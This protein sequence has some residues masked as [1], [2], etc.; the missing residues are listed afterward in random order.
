MTVMNIVRPA[1]PVIIT[2]LLLATP[3]LAQSGRTGSGQSQA[4]AV[5]AADIQRLQDQVYDARNWK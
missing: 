3:A 4:G 2:A 5:T 1:A